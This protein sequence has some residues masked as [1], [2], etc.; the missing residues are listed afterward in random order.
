VMR[1]RRAR[2]MVYLVGTCGYPNY[3]DELI[4]RTWLDHIAA[5]AP[6]AEVWVDCHSPG[7]AQAMF[8]RSHP[9]VRFTDLLWRI[10]AAAPSD[11][12]ADVVEHA[13]RAVRDPGVVPRLDVARAALERVDVVH[14]IGGGYVNT[15][16]PRNLGLLAGA[17]AL[18]RES[19]GVAAMTGQGLQPMSDEAA[20]LVAELAAALAVADV[21]DASSRGVLGAGLEAVSLTGDDSFLGLSERT[22]DRRESPDVMVCAQSDLLAISTEELAALVTTVLSGWGVDAARVGWFEAIPGV[23]RVVY[24]IVTQTVP[25][26]RRYPLLESWQAGMPARRGQRW[27]STRFHP[28][29]MAAAAG[30]WGVAVPVNRG[31][32]DHK[33][34]SLVAQ[35]SGWTVLNPAAPLSAADV[36]QPPDGP[37]GFGDRLREHVAAKRAVAEAVY[38]RLGAA[39]PVP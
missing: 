29:L 7:P 6:R 35:G 14:L 12:P 25:G 34:D 10:C 16:W 15:R 26:I 4:T 24:D 9:H 36:P 28:H 8:S 23:D 3:G 38:G 31:Y 21:R 33:H 30:S 20:P 11:R 1:G 27:L 2:P 22:F 19:G 39:H 37:A 18:A 5:V 17:L 32:Y 13:G